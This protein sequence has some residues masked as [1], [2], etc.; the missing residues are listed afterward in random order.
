[1]PE[2]RLPTREQLKAAYERDLASAFPPSERKPLGEILA[3]LERGEYRPWCLF[4]G[5]EIL[6]EGFVW[7]HVPGY[8]VLDY[9]CVAEPR[10]ND[11]LGAVLLQKLAEEELR[12][13]GTVLLGEAELPA[14]APD[15]AMA[16]RRLGFYRRCGA[17]IAEYNVAIF[18]VPYHTLYWAEGNIDTSALMEAHRET[19]RGSMPEDIYKRFIRIPWDAS[20]GTPEQS[21]WWEG[22]CED[23]GL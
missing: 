2:L 7:A 15:R 19:Y 21:D 10:R 13:H 9:L 12:G 4:D 23:T 22:D 3:E 1:M 14:L 11:G 17:R 18:G 20:M 5:D 8:A 6:G 16:E